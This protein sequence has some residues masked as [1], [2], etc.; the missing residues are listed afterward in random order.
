MV[1]QRVTN[2]Y[3]IFTHMEQLSFYSFSPT[4]ISFYVFML[5]L[6]LLLL[7]LA[8]FLTFLDR[9]ISSFHLHL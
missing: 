5:L 2:L 7:F 1:P 3:S 6:L 9:F 8:L 4:D